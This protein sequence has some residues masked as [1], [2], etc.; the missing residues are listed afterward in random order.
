MNILSLTHM[1]SRK[2]R[3]SKIL[4]ILAASILILWIPNIINADMNFRMDD[5]GI[6]PENSFFIQG[7]MG[8]VWFIYPAVMAVCTVLLIQTERTNNGILK[9]LALPVST[10]ALCLAK[11]ILLV[12][13]SIIYVL[14]STGAYY[15]S[16]AVSSYMTDYSFILI[17]SYVLPMTGKLFLSS[18]P[19]LTVFWMIAVLIRTPI[20]SV[21]AGLASIV[22]SVLLINTK[23]WFL[24]PICY[25]F[26][27]L[28]SEYGNLAEN[29]SASPVKLIPWIPAAAVISVICLIITC[30]SFGRTERR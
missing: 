14:L 11:F 19:M 22:P 1:E 9:M 21:G 2:I 23:I 15:I 28:T 16:A 25:P 18:L 27:V 7:F 6:S 8:M 4:F 20:F 12:L 10:S 26:Y 29:M 17:P 24:Y 13:L 5:I 3:R 30:L